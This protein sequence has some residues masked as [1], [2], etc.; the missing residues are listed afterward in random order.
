MTEKTPQQRD[1][2]M[3][4]QN[5]A[6]YPHMSVA[7]NLAY[8]LK[9]RK[10]DKGE[11]D[12]KVRD[13]AGKLGLEELL[14]RKPSALSGGQRQRVAM[15]RAI[16]REPKA[17]LMDE[18]LSNLDAKLRVSMRAELARLHERLGVTTVY[19][20]HDQ[21]EAM[22]LGE[23]VAVMR[24]GLL[25]QVDTPQNLFNK[26]R[27][28][29]VAAFIGSPA[30]NLV[31]AKIDG[32]RVHFAG[33]DLPLPGG[34][35]LAGEQRRVIL[36]LRPNDFE[37]AAGA[38]PDWPRIRVKPD[39][40]EQLGS[41]TL[42]IFG[43]DAPPVM[44][45]A[46]KAASEAYSDDDGKLFAGEERAMFTASVD[47]KRPLPTGE[48]ELAVDFTALHC[49]DPESGDALAVRRSAQPVA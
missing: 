48:L 25:Q 40:I 27:N 9:L 29:F 6:L 31:E 5:Y 47:G 14:D 42:L 24:D 19:V 22:T 13:I 39:V 3:V 36:G 34:S 43:I 7:D 45:D 17:F 33:I 37:H 12:A 30:M 32:G 18:P 23:R 16:V 15:G 38:D 44:A 21:V 1:I 46:V 20:T 35:P 26:P 2:A 41:E 49:F 10:M 4:F 28:L 11:R 8:G